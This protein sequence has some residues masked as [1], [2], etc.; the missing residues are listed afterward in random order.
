M[1]DRFGLDVVGV[2]DV[3]HGVGVVVLAIAVSLVDRNGGVRDRLE[4]V[5]VGD[6]AVRGIRGTGV[7]ARGR[8]GGRDGGKSDRLRGT[9][10]RALAS[11]ARSP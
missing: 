1:V 11:V 8:C 4:L 2:R 6:V 9:A 7:L 5:G 10:S 3:D